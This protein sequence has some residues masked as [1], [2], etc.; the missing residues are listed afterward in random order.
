MPQGA[1]K[2]VARPMYKGKPKATGIFDAQTK[3]PPT[4][5]AEMYHQ[6]D[7]PCQVDIGGGKGDGEE[8]ENEEKKP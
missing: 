6:G 2:N 3:F 5:F 1:A 4:K 8:D 7:L